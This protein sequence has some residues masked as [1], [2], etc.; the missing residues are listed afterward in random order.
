MPSANTKPVATR[1]SKDLYWGL[2]KEA[3]EHQRT[4]SKHLE[5]VLEDYLRKTKVPSK[6][7]ENGVLLNDGKTIGRCLFFEE[8]GFVATNDGIDGAWQMRKY[9]GVPF[10]D[11]V[12][13]APLNQTKT[14]KNVRDF[15]QQGWEGC[16]V[17]YHNGWKRVGK[18]GVSDA[19]S[20]EVQNKRLK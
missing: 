17:F 12:F 9:T 2:L 20:T 8:D 14:V 1:I 6:K 19:K 3:A 15:V 5:A 18:G 7:A 11:S 4:I 16:N 10:G 13:T